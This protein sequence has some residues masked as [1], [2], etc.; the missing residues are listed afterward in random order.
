M[1]S[2]RDSELLFLKKELVKK[3]VVNNL[4]AQDASELRNQ[5]TGVKG[6]N[7]GV[8]SPLFQVGVTLTSEQTAFL[9]QISVCESYSSLVHLFIEFPISCLVPVRRSFFSYKLDFLLKFFQFFLASV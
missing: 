9:V 2:E 7:I 5:A 3:A 6:S 4:S 1:F 8:M